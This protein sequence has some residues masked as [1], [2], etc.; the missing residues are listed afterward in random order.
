MEA[1]KIRI[2]CL[3]NKFV[4][5]LSLVASNVY[6]CLIE[7]GLIFVS[8]AFSD[9]SCWAKKEC[10]LS[11]RDPPILTKLKI[12]IVSL[13]LCTKRLKKI[14]QAGCQN[15]QVGNSVRLLLP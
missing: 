2:E 4:S 8:V 10:Y 13:A 12:N 1:E 11:I 15:F 3:N 14:S 5:G 9:R 6:L 7:R